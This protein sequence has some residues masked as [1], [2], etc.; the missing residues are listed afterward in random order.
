MTKFIHAVDGSYILSSEIVEIKKA[1]KDNCTIETKQGKTHIVKNYA[2]GVVADIE[3]NTRM[4]IPAQPGYSVTFLRPSGS[5]GEG[6][7]VSAPVVAFSIT[8]KHQSV[9]P[10]EVEPIVAGGFDG[11]FEQALV[12]PGGMVISDHGYGPTT[13]EEWLDAAKAESKAREEAYEEEDDLDEEEYK[14]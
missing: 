13:M 1:G 10:V 3:A 5:H 6:E 8:T 7:T 4:I 9:F 14:N 2:L 11:W 12:F